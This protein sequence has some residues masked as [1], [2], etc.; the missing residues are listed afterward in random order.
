[1]LYKIAQFLVY[2]QS[3]LYNFQIYTSSIYSTESVYNLQT[4]KN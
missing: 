4:Y 3:Y 2:F 1:M